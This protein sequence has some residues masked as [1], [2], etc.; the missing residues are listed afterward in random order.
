MEEFQPRTFT[1]AVKEAISLSREEAIRLHNDFIAVDHVML[2]LLRHSENS[3]R[4][5]LV[6][7]GIDIELLKQEIEQ[8]V[9]KNF[10]GL[11]VVTTGSIPLSKDCEKL[12][13][14]T[15]TDAHIQKTNDISCAIMLMG[16]MRN[17]NALSTQILRKK[18]FTY[19]TLQSILARNNFTDFPLGLDSDVIDVKR[20]NAENKFDESEL[21]HILEGALIEI[22]DHFEPAI[23]VNDI[24]SEIALLISNLKAL[25]RGKMI[26]VFG[27]WGRGK[28]FLMNL[29]W[30]S[31]R[32]N[33]PGYK[34]VKFHAWRYQDTQAVWAYLYESLSEAYFLCESKNRFYKFIDRIKKIVRLNIIRKGYYDV[35][36]FFL[37]LSIFGLA[38]YA[39]LA[40]KP[41]EF[42][43]R[44]DNF[45]GLRI[46][47]LLIP[48]S[49]ALVTFLRNEIKGSYTSAVALVKG[50]SDG[51][52]YS[53][54]LGVQ[55]EIQKEIR[56]LLKVWFDKDPDGKILLVVDDIDRCNEEKVVQIIDALRVMLEDDE[57]APRVTVLAAIDERILKM[58]VKRKYF[59]FIDKDYAVKGDASQA[60][61][62]S[63]KMVGEYLD[64]IFIAGVKLGK[65]SATNKQELFSIF[66]SGQVA[67]ASQDSD[68][69]QNQTDNDGIKSQPQQVGAS[70]VGAS[71]QGKKSEVQASEKNILLEHL[72][73]EFISNTLCAVKAEMT[74]RQI[75]IFYYRYLLAR[76]LLH[77]KYFSFNRLHLQ[78]ARNLLAA[79]L[80]MN[81][82]EYGESLSG[83]LAK[84]ND[85]EIGDRPSTIHVLGT[86]YSLK[87]DL[88]Q[89]I[90]S[91]AEMV[92]GY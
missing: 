56:A 27:S 66:T 60:N 82:F 58:A 72:E 81:C 71:Q 11:D 29:V 52:S 18:K 64:K 80:I 61:L 53:S 70:S 90:F 31:L 12:L 55:A 34:Q 68:T 75:K 33:S 87:H 26:G 69:A 76:N 86:E 83:T 2:G 1:H 4:Y 25:E 48:L 88:I 22:S 15:Y 13:K 84:M 54:L 32:K 14:L 17:D 73:Y 35:I 40:S 50:Y 38:G 49:I 46:F 89:E 92:I 19:A 5:A 67:A 10:P 7:H 20:T 77:K 65:L 44:G 43:A 23:G 78:S 59:D 24:A 62:V 85:S 57:I 39:L 41:F 51:K 42:D 45:K 8:A 6:E 79:V 3:A 36:L 9:I 37:I 63:N 28:T 21:V 30:D 74:P 91:V 16:I 47:G